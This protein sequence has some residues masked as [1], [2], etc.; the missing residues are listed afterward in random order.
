MYRLVYMSTPKRP[1]SREDLDAMLA[2]ATRNNNRNGITGILIQDH[3]RFLQYLEGNEDRVEETFARISLD[4]R[5]HAIFRLK[6]G[7]IVRRQFPG[8]SMA[9]K[10]VDQSGSLTNVVREL[11]KACDRDVAEELLNF[12]AARDR[13]T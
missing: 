4:K 10:T 9:S 1:L 13:A 11:V 8:W 12:A 6:S 7:V 5:H 2:A 3:K